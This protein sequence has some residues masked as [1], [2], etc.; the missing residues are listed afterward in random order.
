[1]VSASSAFL[2][3][4]GAF[5]AAG[6]FAAGFFAAGFFAA[7]FF[8]A[9]FFAAGFFAAG[10][11]AAGF[12]VSAFSSS[13]WASEGSSVVG[14]AVAAISST[15]D[16]SFFAAFL[17]GAFFGASAA[18]SVLLFSSRL[19]TIHLLFQCIQDIE[20]SKSAALNVRIHLIH[21]AVIAST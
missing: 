16:S 10:F 3:F 5:F 12:F 17:D 13:G 2:L 15:S 19:T 14:S 20:I 9:G 1:M 6:F 21:H 8:A 4:A 18:V 7:G 11:F